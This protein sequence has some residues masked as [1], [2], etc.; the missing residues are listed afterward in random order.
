MQSFL[1][2]YETGGKD[3]ADGWTIDDF[4]GPPLMK[5]DKYNK[6]EFKDEICS[7]WV[8]D[9]R[10]PNAFAEGYKLIM[11]YLKSDPIFNTERYSE[12]QV[13]LAREG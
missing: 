1:I 6:V 13:L 4:G 12:V 7:V 10:L 2:E 3:L 8:K 9:N 5:E 11:D